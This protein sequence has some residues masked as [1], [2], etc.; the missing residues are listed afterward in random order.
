MSITFTSHQL[1]KWARVEK[2]KI[3]YYIAEG[4]TSQ[5]KLTNRGKLLEENMRKIRELLK[6]FTKFHAIVLLLLLN[7]PF[8][9]TKQRKVVHLL[10]NKHINSHLD[11][12]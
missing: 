7:P 6:P 9:T 2:H 8:C 3:E 4:K 5:G 10:K 12:S 11:G 1:G